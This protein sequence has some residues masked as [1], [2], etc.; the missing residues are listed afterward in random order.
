MRQQGDEEFYQKLRQPIF[1]NFLTQEKI[2]D[3]VD[4]LVAQGYLNKKQGQYI[5]GET[6]PRLRRFYLLPKIHKPREKWL[7]QDMPPGR[8]IV[9]DCGS[10]SYRVAELLDYYLKPLAVRHKSYLKDTWDFLDKNRDIRVSE[11]MKFFT[12]DVNSLYTNIETERGLR[13]IK[14]CFTRY[15]DEDRPD[16]V[17]LQLL[18]MSLTCND[19][20]F[21]GQYYL[22]VKGTAMGKRFAPAYA[23]IYMAEWEE[24]ALLKCTKKPESYYRYLDDIWG[25]WS[26]SD[27]DF[28]N[29]VGCL[30][31]HHGSIKVTYTLAEQEIN[32]LDVTVYKGPRFVQTKQLD[33]KV[34]FKPTDTHALLH[35]ASHH[36]K[37]TFRG[38]VKGQ[39]IRFNRICSQKTEE[40]VARQ[41]LFRALRKRGYSRSFLRSIAKEDLSRTKNVDDPEEEKRI[42]PLVL[43]YSRSNMGVAR[44]I[45]ENFTSISTN[46][47]FG[48]GFRMLAAYKRGRNLRDWLVSSRMESG[49]KR[50]KEYRKKYIR[51]GEQVVCKEIGKPVPLNIKNCIYLIRCR[52]CGKRYV[53]ET[54]NSIR[55]RMSAHR[56]NI[57]HKVQVKG[58]IT[59][60]FIEHGVKNVW[61]TGLEH[62]HTW[63]KRDRLKKEWAWIKQLNTLFPRGL[64]ISYQSQPNNQE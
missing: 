8:P 31:N 4:S 44:E 56:Y 27:E 48:E 21:D 3:L 12:M 20:E 58:H 61:V 1:T 33:F 11:N 55:T 6:N 59:R 28:Q 29:F 34:F 17:I 39:L 42:L 62:N 40:D 64:N 36:P 25:I 16:R 57:N 7:F 10:E 24:Q 37:H 30:N 32:F 5:R 19:F 2:R 18:E 63:S 9:S 51:T 49:V 35:R 22:Q 60:H 23:N 53:G 15:P 50:S 45:R 13:A 41:T 47:W 54:R 26:H 43:E 46:T 52:K 14:N 38:I